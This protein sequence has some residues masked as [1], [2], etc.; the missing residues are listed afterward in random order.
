MSS[1]STLGRIIKVTQEVIDYRRWIKEKWGGKAPPAPEPGETSLLGVCHLRTLAPRVAVP[2]SPSVVTVR[3]RKCLVFCN[4][5][6]CSH[7][8]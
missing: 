8:I 5:R 1:Y 4:V 7:E 3:L 2:L 6:V